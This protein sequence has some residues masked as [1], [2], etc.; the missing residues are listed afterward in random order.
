MTDFLRPDV[1]ALDVTDECTE[2]ED[3]YTYGLH[4][5]EFNETHFVIVDIL[6]CTAEGNGIADGAVVFY[7]GEPETP[8]PGDCP[9]EFILSGDSGE[10]G[11]VYTFMYG[12]TPYYAASEVSS[13]TA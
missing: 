1:P 2:G 3:E 9:D 13:F 8:P 4:R 6:S 12:S 7:Y 10:G 5:F 11:A